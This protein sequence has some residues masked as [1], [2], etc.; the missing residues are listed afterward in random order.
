M[1]TPTCSLLPFS[2]LPPPLGSVRNTGGCGAFYSIVI[3]SAEF[4]GL[5]TIKA[6]RLVNE[7]LKTIIKGIHG[8]QLKTIAEE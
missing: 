5:S 4:K 8:L 2:V 7:E 3:S 1:L 6:H